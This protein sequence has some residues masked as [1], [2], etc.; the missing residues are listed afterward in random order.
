[1]SFGIV[2]LM[3]DSN[4]SSLFSHRMS[5]EMFLQTISL[6]KGFS[7][8]SLLWRFINITQWIRQLKN[9]ITSET[10]SF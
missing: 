4:D 2:F 10:T 1:V 5:S 6:V 7:T 3:K 8:I 9:P